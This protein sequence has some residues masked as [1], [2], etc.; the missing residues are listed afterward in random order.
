VAVTVIAPTAT[1]ADALATGLFVLGPERGLQLL[2]T[3]RG[4]EALYFD[5]DLRVH[6]SQG[7]PRGSRAVAAAAG[8]PNHP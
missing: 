3:L 4:V 6:V 7:F 1:D 5:P 8:H 2:S